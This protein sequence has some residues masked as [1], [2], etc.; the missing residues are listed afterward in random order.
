MKSSDTRWLS[1]ERCVR[2]VKMSY[3]A[4]VLALDGIYNESHRPEALGL[5]QILSMP[6]TLHAMLKFSHRPLNLVKHCKLCI[7]ICLP[8]QP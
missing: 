7:L 3:S 6:S 1:H 5:S 8:F 4:P 2:A